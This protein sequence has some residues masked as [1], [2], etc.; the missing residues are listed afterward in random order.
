[1][2]ELGCQSVPRGSTI[3]SVQSQPMTL[4]C[5]LYLSSRHYSRI[6]ESVGSIMPV[7]CTGVHLAALGISL[8]DPLPLPCCTAGLPTLQYLFE[9]LQ[10]NPSHLFGRG[11]CRPWIPCWIPLCACYKT[12]T[13]ISSNPHSHGVYSA[14]I[15]KL[16]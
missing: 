7:G 16:H 8:L 10:R 14:L 2:P 4:Y 12:K 9:L 11:A 5:W 15:I 13:L 1:M 3:K 6:L